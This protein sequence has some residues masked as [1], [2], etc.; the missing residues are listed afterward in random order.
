MAWFKCLWHGYCYAWYAS[1]FNHILMGRQWE[2]YT[3][4]PRVS[5]FCQLG[6]AIYSITGKGA[7]TKE[8]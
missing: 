7:T 2:C 5:K 8:I 6:H 1:C 4:V 3:L